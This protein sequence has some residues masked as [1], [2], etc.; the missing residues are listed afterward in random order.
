MISWTMKK[1]SVE[2]GNESD[3]TETT[4]DGPDNKS[5]AGSRE[6]GMFIIV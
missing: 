4:V 3:E 2:S 6:F 1:Q 5:P